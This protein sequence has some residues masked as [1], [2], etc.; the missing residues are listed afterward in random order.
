[1]SPEHRTEGSSERDDQ[2]STSNGTATEPAGGGRR[3]RGERIS[4]WFASV[5]VRTGLA[6]IGLIV[7]VF[8]LGQAVGLDLL[9][10]AAEAITSQTGRWL[11]VAFFGLLLIGAAQHGLTQRG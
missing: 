11:V 3:S 4:T 9:G 1:M 10:M 8:A 7:V 6:V 5:A 2:A